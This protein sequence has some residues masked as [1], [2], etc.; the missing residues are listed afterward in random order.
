MSLPG[1]IVER[2]MERY[3][4]QTT[5]VALRYLPVVRL[6]RQ[7]GASKVLEV[8]SGDLGL[9]PY[10]REFD[11][12]GLDTAFSKPN[13]DMV[14]VEGSGARLPFDDRTFDAVISVDSLEH[15]PAGDRESA[16]TEVLRTALRRAIIA[17]PSGERAMAQDEILAERYRQVR[18]EDYPFLQEHLE[19]S[20]PEADELERAL[21]RALKRLGRGGAIVLHRNTNLWLRS[22]L[23]KGWISRNK[24]FHNL[25]I[26]GLMPLAGLLSRLNIGHCY[27][28]I[29]VVDLSG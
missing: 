24:F 1:K 25:A 18:G 23:M 26:L 5:E 14:Q 8:G 12:T 19:N 7:S 10:S 3:P 4:D 28:V 22:L 17:V 9:T 11:L 2:L 21:N 6:L 27:R 29:A 15:M 16:V 20:L 13:P